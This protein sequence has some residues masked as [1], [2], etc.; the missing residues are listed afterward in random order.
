MTYISITTR[1]GNRTPIPYIR[2]STGKQDEE[3]QLR[4][5]KERY[6]TIDTEPSGDPLAGD[7][8][9]Y[10][11]FQDIPDNAVILV[12]HPDRILK[13]NKMGLV[14]NLIACL[15]ESNIKVH[16]TRKQLQYWEALIQSCDVGQFVSLVQQ[17]SIETANPSAETATFTDQQTDMVEEVFKQY[18]NARYHFKSMDQEFWAFTSYMG[19]AI[20]QVLKSRFPQQPSAKKSMGTQASQVLCFK[21]LAGLYEE[22]LTKPKELSQRLASQYQV[23]QKGDRPINPS[24]INR[25]LKREDF[26]EFLETKRQLESNIKWLDQVGINAPKPKEETSSFEIQRAMDKLGISKLYPDQ[27]EALDA[28][29]EGRSLC[30]QTRTGGGKSLVPRIY[31]KAY[32]EELVVVVLPTNALI[33]NLADKWIE[34]LGKGQVLIID[35]SAPGAIFQL[36]QK[37]RRPNPG[38]VLITPYK[39]ME[40]QVQR[41]L[42]GRVGLMV[43]D[44]AHNIAYAGKVYRDEYRAKNI[45]SMIREIGPE[46]L[47]F[48]SATL[49]KAALKE[50]KK[51]GAYEMVSGPLKRPNLELKTHYCGTG[52]LKRILLYCYLMAVH[53]RQRGKCI[54]Y[55][56][57]IKDLLKAKKEM[58][59]LGLKIHQY[60][61]GADETKMSLR[62]RKRALKAFGS[63]PTGIMFATSAFGEGMDF[64]DVELVIA[65]AQA[66]STAELYQWIGRG[67]R[68]GRS[69]LGVQLLDKHGDFLRRMLIDSSKD[70]PEAWEFQ[71]KAYQKYLQLLKAVG[72]PSMNDLIRQIQGRKRIRILRKQAS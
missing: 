16:F 11:R 32:L 43:F 4:I 1:E 5:L 69:A 68:D 13:T 70:R 39:L 33:G 60:Y 40:P 14:N 26:R 44:E 29:E 63:D 24:Q 45:R 52:G 19:F 10:E 51:I 53:E 67:G 6:P 61:S 65:Y 41:A 18:R 38:V 58:E 71:N 34:A 22:G 2:Y 28:L 42:K 27:V 57:N 23:L 48:T 59:A 31:A 64:P 62:D 54:V 12:E 37:V 49:D 46:K 30:Y 35:Q 66:G 55:F 56:N 72:E 8:D 50:I 47:L 36:P 21:A 15:E 7:T 17:R 3:R 9:P 25:Y 20:N